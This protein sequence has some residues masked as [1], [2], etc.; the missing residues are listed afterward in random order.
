[1]SRA[2]LGLAV[3]LSAASLAACGDARHDRSQVAGEASY[4][5]RGIYGSGAS[6]SNLRGVV[7]LGFN[8]I[9]SGPYRDEMQRLA[10]RGVKGFV[11]LGGYSNER[12][13]FRKSN[14]WVRTHVAAIAGHPGVG[15]Y[16]ID[17]EPDAARCPSA[18]R[19][20]RARSRLVKSLDPRPV[21][22]IVTYHVEQLRRFA[23]TVDVIG[24][25]HYPCTRKGGC[26]FS[27]IDRQA[28]EADRLGIRY[29]GVIQAHGDDWYRLPTAQELH[30]QFVHWRATAMEGYL[31][32]SWNW[33]DGEPSLWLANH[34]EL[35]RQLAIENG[36]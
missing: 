12:C 1:M 8:L 28:A 11:W 27:R 4:S 7:R 5:V 2:S 14:R 23:G 15:A 16:F 35:M 9:D 6:S 36:A 10:A 19:Q 29:W 30:R 32:F 18:P 31:V 17:D 24:L 22:F 33:P 26:D 13:R 34:A 20:M 25:D 21:T 3:V